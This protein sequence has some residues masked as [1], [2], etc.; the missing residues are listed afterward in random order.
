MSSQLCGQTSG[1]RCRQ[2]RAPS[3]AS[4]KG[5]ALLLPAFGSCQQP[6][7][8]RA[9]SCNTGGVLHVP[10]S[11][12]GPLRNPPVTGRRAQP[13]PTCPRGHQTPAAET[14]F[15]DQITL[16]GSGWIQI[17][18]RTL[19]ISACSPRAGTVLDFLCSLCHAHSH[20]W[21]QGRLTFPLCGGENR[22]SGGYEA[23]GQAAQLQ[24]SRASTPTQVS[25]SPSA[26]LWEP[27]LWEPWQGGAAESQS[28]PVRVLPAPSPL[29]GAGHRVPAC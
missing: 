9:R 16:A 25:L 6:W 24:S 27:S 17:W 5:P 15:P 8:A 2:G 28:R 21:R 3:E 23:G 11:S 29:S 12:H 13:F 10:V 1:I 22:D 4:R 26:S 7:R 19:S 14:L 20:P 18:G